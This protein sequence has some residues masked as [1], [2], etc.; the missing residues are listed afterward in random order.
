MFFVGS[1]LVDS[2]DQENTL[3][4]EDFAEN[5]NNELA[6]LNKVEEGY[7]REVL[8][9]ADDYD[10][11]VLADTLILKDKFNENNTYYFDLFAGLDMEITN[12]SIDGKN[13]TK[14]VFKK[15]IE[16]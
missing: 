2:K 1:Y 7:S 16:R 8:I 11:E 13:Y 10:I 5:I 4:A 3:Q 14:L 6:I 12:E 9:T 15:G